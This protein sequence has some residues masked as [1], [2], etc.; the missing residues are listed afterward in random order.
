MGEQRLDDLERDFHS[1]LLVC[2]RECSHG[3]WGLFGQN[4]NPESARFL[5]WENARRL[6]ETSMEI[7]GLR[8]E[9]G[10]PNQLVERFLYYCSQKGPNVL[11]E[12]KLA[13]AFLDEIE[14]GDFSSH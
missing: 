9:F 12:P 1:L 5:Y 2:L 11:G 8:A 4:E 10:Q 13:A 6:K 14:R 3:R 7:H